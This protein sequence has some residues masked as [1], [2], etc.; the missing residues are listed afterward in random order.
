MTDNEPRVVRKR[1]AVEP[2]KPMRVTRRR[3]E[4]VPLKP[5]ERPEVTHEPKP[6][7]PST[8]SE[9]RLAINRRKRS[10]RTQIARTLKAVED[11]AAR[12]GDDPELDMDRDELEKLLRLLDEDAS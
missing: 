6:E 2:E 5:G 4:K 8:R 12:F 3:V 9:E 11:A 7:L 1:I 10:I